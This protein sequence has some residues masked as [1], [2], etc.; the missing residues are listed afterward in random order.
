VI[1][2]R[3]QRHPAVLVD[4]SIAVVVGTVAADLGRSGVHRG[5]TV[6]AVL[7]VV[8]PVA[9]GV[10]WLRRVVVVIGRGVVVVIVNGTGVVVIR[11]AV[12][13]VHV[14]VVG[15]GVVVIHGA[16]VIAG[17]VAPRGRHDGRQRHDDRVHP[18]HVS[19]VH[20]LHATEELL[21]GRAV[22][23]IKS[24]PCAAQ[25]SWVRYKPR[26]AARYHEVQAARPTLESSSCPWCPP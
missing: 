3:V 13:I 7:G 1:P 6:V 12:V 18:Q 23:P 19:G 9:V 5:I 20:V 17:P 11:G 25:V 22:H 24:T 14:I 16:V 21:L 15:R 8:E 10:D 4:V 26:G 2:A